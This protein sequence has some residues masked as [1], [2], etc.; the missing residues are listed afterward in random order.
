[1]LNTATALGYLQDA[2]FIWIHTLFL[3]RVRTQGRGTVTDVSTSGV[4]LLILAG[5]ARMAAWVAAPHMALLLK[6]DAE[7]IMKEAG[8]GD[9][10]TGLLSAVLGGFYSRPGMHYAVV[11][12][13]AFI[14]A[15]ATLWHGWSWHGQSSPGTPPNT[16]LRKHDP[17]SALRASIA[18]VFAS[19]LFVLQV[20]PAPVAAALRSAL[21]SQALSMAMLQDHTILAGLAFFLLTLGSALTAAAVWAQC[22]C[23]VELVKVTTGAQAQAQSAHSALQEQDIAPALRKRKGGSKLQKVAASSSDHADA[24]AAPAP[25]GSASSDSPTYSEASAGPLPQSGT[26]TAAILVAVLW[27]VTSFLLSVHTAAHSRSSPAFAAGVPD[28]PW[29]WG[30]YVA[31]HAHGSFVGLALLL[32]VPQLHLRRGSSNRSAVGVLCVAAGVAALLPALM[33]NTALRRTL[34]VSLDLLGR[35][36]MSGAVAGIVSAALMGGPAS[37][38]CVAGVAALVNWLVQGVGGVQAA[39]MAAQYAGRNKGSFF[40]GK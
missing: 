28:Q 38:V 11:A 10:V 5:A 26:V 16:I 30:S 4:L 13:A 2:A 34:G 40:T 20:S 1:M 33:A 3:M 18:A 17:S 7:G 15:A 27:G 31:S 25:G 14:A 8:R 39:S 37:V 12:S 36:C 21:Q 9:T 19:A 35:P 24:A 22:R 6:L 23:W 32:G 29:A